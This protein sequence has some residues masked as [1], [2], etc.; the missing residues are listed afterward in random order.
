MSIVLREGAVCLFD[1]VT[2]FSWTFV[3]GGVSR[4]LPHRGGVTAGDR[5][6]GQLRDDSSVG[7]PSRVWGWW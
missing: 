6:A 5:G 1:S 7:L 3:A 4:D 2:C